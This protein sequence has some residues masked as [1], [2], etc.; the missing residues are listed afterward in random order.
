MSNEAVSKEQSARWPSFSLRYTFNP[1]DVDAPV[2]FAPDELVVF[3]PTR[4]RSQAWVAAA[5][6]S[7]VAIEDVR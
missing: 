7:Y 6:G 5:R 1:D 2:E 3:D 4:E